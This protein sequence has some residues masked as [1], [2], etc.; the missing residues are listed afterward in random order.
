MRRL[1][2]AVLAVVLAVLLLAAPAG[3]QDDGDDPTAETSTTVPVIDEGDLD[4][5]PEP[6]SGR[7]PE[8]AGDRGGAGQ[9]VLFGVVLLGIA[10]IIGLAV[11]DAR[12]SR[13]RASSDT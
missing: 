9:L 5:L 8:D 3:A 10:V 12:R 4:F 7:P 6:N 2:A 13:A 1:L 11:R